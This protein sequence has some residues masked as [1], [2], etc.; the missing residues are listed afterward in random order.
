M[1]HFLGQDVQQR[2]V[3]K[4]AAE[5][6]SNW[7]GPPCK[8]LSET[9]EILEE[10]LGTANPSMCGIPDAP[11]PALLTVK[12]LQRCVDDDGAGPSDA[13]SPVSSQDI[14]LCPADELCLT[15]CWVCTGHSP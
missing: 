8:P 7:W 3:R 15:R 12:E 2:I 11:D 9:A 5:F 13:S 10:I 4:G 1:Q 14:S 6:L